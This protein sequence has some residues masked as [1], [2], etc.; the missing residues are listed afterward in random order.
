[1]EVRWIQGFLGLFIL[2]LKRLLLKDPR[3]AA[4]AQDRIPGRGTEASEGFSK[5]S[6]FMLFS[7]V[8]AS[9]GGELVTIPSS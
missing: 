5:E 2:T 1:M 9:A 4:T 8:W 7:L 6:W 3:W